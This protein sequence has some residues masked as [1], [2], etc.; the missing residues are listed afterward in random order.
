MASAS[1]KKGVSQRDTG[2]IITHIL[3]GMEVQSYYSNDPLFD[4][5]D[6]FQTSTDF[7]TEEAFAKMKSQLLTRGINVRNFEFPLSPRD[8]K[9]FLYEYT[10][11]MTPCEGG[12]VAGATVVL[13]NIF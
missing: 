13:K 2:I 1:F 4:S 10:A 12:E 3:D 11:C 9:M 8:A 7:I 5:V 6:G